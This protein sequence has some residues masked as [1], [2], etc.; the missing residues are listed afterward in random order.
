MARPQHGFWSAP[1]GYFGSRDSSGSKC[2][3]MN[4]S[5]SGTQS[6]VRS[7]GT[8]ITMR[9]GSGLGTETSTITPR[10]PATPSSSGSTIPTASPTRPTSAGSSV[11][12]RLTCRFGSSASNT[13]GD[14]STTTTPRQL[15]TSSREKAYTVDGRSSGD[16]GSSSTIP[17]WQRGRIRVPGRR[18]LAAGSTTTPATKRSSVATQTRHETAASRGSRTISLPRRR[19][20]PVVMRPF[21][22][23]R[24]APNATGNKTPSTNDQSSPSTSL[25]GG[26][27]TSG[28]ETAGSGVL[29]GSRV[30]KL[31]RISRPVRNGLSNK[32]KR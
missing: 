18:N 6:P 31:K 13:S 8:Y 24:V 4:S 7:S 9:Y 15:A 20:K 2:D 22:K 32:F 16:N 19:K 3:T 5:G 14:T 29:S 17:T 30:T 21:P 26:S 23:E 1:G 25:G 27:A 28:K 11:R 12:R 10:N